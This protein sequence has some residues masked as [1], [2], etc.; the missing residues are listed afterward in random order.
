MASHSGLPHNENNPNVI[1][2]FYS[3]TPS[4]PNCVTPDYHVSP[5]EHFDRDSLGHE[6]NDRHDVCIDKILSEKKI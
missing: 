5:L 2:L 1:P 3:K 4:A 6:D